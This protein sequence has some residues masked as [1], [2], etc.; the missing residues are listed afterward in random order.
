MCRARDELHVWGTTT[1]RW[2]SLA[3][4]WR[5]VSHC[6]HSKLLPHGLLLSLSGLLMPLLRWGQPG[7]SPSLVSGEAWY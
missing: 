2:R 1:G 3:G 7:P 6:V 4:L 5:D